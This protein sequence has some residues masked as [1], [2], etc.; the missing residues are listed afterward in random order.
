MHG[1]E[2]L[3][4]KIVKPLVE[5]GA[6]SH[7]VGRSKMNAAKFFFGIQVFWALAL[8]PGGLSAET[9]RA[10]VASNFARVLAELSQRFEQST[11]HKVLLAHGST[12]KHYAQIVNAAP[13]ELF[14]AADAA[15]PERLEEEGRAI[16][17]S[18]FTYAVGKLV[19][20]SPKPGLVD[21]AGTVLGRGE[22]ARLA[23]ANPDLAPY[24]R[25]AREVL[26]RLGLWSVV[27]EG[28]VRGENIGQTFQFVRSGNADLGFVALSQLRRPGHAIEG[29]YWEV[30]Q[31]L[32]TP[33]AQQAVLLR[34]NRTARDFLA[35]VRNDASLALI[36]DYGYG[37]P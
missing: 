32:Y 5:P 34:E 28:A 7:C 18:R 29:G 33:I 2:P 36:R 30:P 22:F 1:R 17:G 13:F 19:L 8:A 35:F 16:A 25:A 3:V 27:K 37:I 14:F 21:P 10:A 26:E 20:W 4:S 12:G 15:R 6:C 23:I 11:G 24:G 9:I 31:S